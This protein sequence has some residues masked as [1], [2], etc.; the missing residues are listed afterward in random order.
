MRIPTFTRS[1]AARVLQGLIGLWLLIEGS[2]I[3]TLS[4]LL[5]MMAGVVVAVTA[6]G[7]AADSGHRREHRAQGVVPQTP[8][9]RRL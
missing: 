6:A 4:G 2:H 1:P 5:M 3:A 8:R 9:H 7:N